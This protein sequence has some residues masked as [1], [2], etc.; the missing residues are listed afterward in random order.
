[1]LKRWRANARGNLVIPKLLCFAYGLGLLLIFGI[2]ASVFGEA[3][4]T[5]TSLFVTIWFAVPIFSI[6]LKRP[7]ILA[8][9]TVVGIRRVQSTLITIVGIISAMMFMSL[10]D[11]NLRF[12]KAFIKGHQGVELKFT[13]DGDAYREP[14]WIARTS[15]GK[16]ALQLLPYAIVSA[17]FLFPT[18]TWKQT[19]AAISKKER[20]FP[21]TEDG[22]RLEV[23]RTNL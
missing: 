16:W 21:E 12:G 6:C 9:F 13:D 5:F 20:Q 19:L 11:L 3:F 10:L 18:I 23:Y 1:M 7:P 2:S 14:I 17:V 4:R 8:C 22:Q 15:T